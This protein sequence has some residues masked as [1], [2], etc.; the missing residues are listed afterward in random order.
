MKQIVVDIMSDGQIKV[1][2]KGF[3]GPTCL[4]ES[5]F[6]KDLLGKETASHLTTAFYQRGQKVVKKHIP[7]C[8]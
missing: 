2:T 3:N 1:E 8:G 4:E 5:Q 6:L 7:L